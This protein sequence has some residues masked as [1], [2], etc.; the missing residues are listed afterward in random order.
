MLLFGVASFQ[1][2][3]V[4]P[5]RPQYPCR[6][7][8]H[9]TSNY[10][11]N[12]ILLS[13]FSLCWH[14]HWWLQCKGGENCWLFSTSHD[15]AGGTAQWSL[16]SSLYGQ[17]VIK[18]SATSKDF[19]D[20][21][22]KQLLLFKSWPWVQS[23]FNV[24]CDESEAWLAP[25]LLLRLKET[26]CATIWVVSRTS[27]PFTRI[28]TLKTSLMDYGYSDLSIWQNIN[29]VNLSLKGKDWQYCSQWKNLNF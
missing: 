10:F 3:A 14:L 2:V 9:K 17:A 29:A 5:G 8:T 15:G 13:A 25:L 11:H 4:V 6:G 23:R 24:L 28:F 18:T 20:Q 26:H 22:A 19:L 27:C 16:C 21:A 7:S 12:V 1:A